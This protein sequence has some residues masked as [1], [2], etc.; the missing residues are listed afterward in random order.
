MD[1]DLIVGEVMPYILR[2]IHAYGAAVLTRAEDTAADETVRAGQRLLRSVLGA[3][4]AR[5]GIEQAVTALASAENDPDFQAALRAQIKLAVRDDSGLVHQLAALLPQ[6]PNQSSTGGRSPVITNNSGQISVGDNSPNIQVKRKF[7]ILP[8]GFI[9]I[10]KNAGSA[11]TAHPLAAAAC[12]VLVVGSVAGGVVLSQPAA[13]GLSAVPCPSAAS[14]TSA[15][16]GWSVTP[17]TIITEGADSGI[18]IQSQ[19]Q[20]WAG[21]YLPHVANANYTVTVTGRS[22][23]GWGVAARAT[24]ATDGTLTGHAIQY[25]LGTGSYRDVDYPGD[26]GPR[27]PTSVNSGWHTLAVTVIGSTYVLSLDRRQVAHGTLP[28]TAEASGGAF[29]RVWNGG[30][31]EIR[32]PVITTG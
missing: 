1:A 16:A 23:Y 18:C 24:A 5:P 15:P 11:A 28:Q 27:Y 22:L 12:T 3:K 19:T 20:Y 2:A 30:A 13:A 29:I 8:L 10:T 21:I 6:T 31:A 9:K 7:W 32:I 4:T 26:T 25:E 14:S 17:N